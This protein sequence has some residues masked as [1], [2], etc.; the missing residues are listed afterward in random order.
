MNIVITGVSAGFGKEMAALFVASGH[1]VIGIARRKERLDTLSEQLGSQFKAYE[2]D[3][4]DRKQSEKIC[5]EIIHNYKKIDVLINNAGLALGT[6]P[7][8]SCDFHDWETLVTRIRF[9]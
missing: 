4:S 6:E 3:V 1:Q 7:A 8:E 9:P 5:E 2:L